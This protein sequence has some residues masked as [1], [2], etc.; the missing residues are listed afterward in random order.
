MF[1]KLFIL[2]FI[3]VAAV[4]PSA[5]NAEETMACDV[6]VIGAGTGGCSAAIQ[7]AR[8]GMTQGVELFE[9]LPPEHAPGTNL[10]E[11]VRRSWEE[12]VGW[13]AA[14][15]WKRARER[16]QNF[17]PNDPVAQ[18]LLSEMGMAANAPANWDG[19]VKLNSKS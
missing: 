6:A 10:K 14:G 2:A 12:A 7:A 9:L 3:A 11:A 17:F 4:L 8:M 15:D 16:F 1:K 5:A 18:I 13:Y 19:V